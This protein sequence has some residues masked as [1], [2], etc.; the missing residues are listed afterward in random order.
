MLLRLQR[1]GFL[2]D[3]LGLPWANVD[4][5]RRQILVR[6][7]LGYGEVVYTKNDGSFRTIDM[8]EPV[9]LALKA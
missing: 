3:P 2:G 4:F 9:Y 5:S 6:E 8:S 1:T 7:A